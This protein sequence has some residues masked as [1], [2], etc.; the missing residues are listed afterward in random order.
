MGGREN[1]PPI[2]VYV[3]HKAIVAKM[4][5]RER[6]K[7]CRKSKELL[8]KRGFGENNKL[9]GYGYKINEY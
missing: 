7:F 3:Q 8:K 9:C 6:C 2:V 4:C 1:R 5:A